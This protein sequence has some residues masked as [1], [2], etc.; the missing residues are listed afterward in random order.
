MVHT[1][2]IAVVVSYNGS[3]D[4]L[5]TV[6]ALQNRVG[7]IHI[8]DN[9]SSH[10]T[11]DILNKLEQESDISIT[12]LNKNHGIGYALNIG[13][14]KGGELGFN[15]ILTMDQDSRVSD[16]MVEEFCKVI[17]LNCKLSCLTPTISIFENESS[18]N[19]TMN[20][21]NIVK[22]AITSG[23]LIRL[24]VFETVGLYNEELFIDCVDFDF[25]LRLRDAG[26]TINLV[27]QAKLFHQLGDV[28]DVP[29]I[30]SWFYTSHS[31]L[32]RYY[33]YRNWGFMIERYSFKFPLFVLK[34]SI[35]HILLLLVIPFYDK[36]P[37]ES[38]KFIY[39]GLRDYFKNQYG[40]LKI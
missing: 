33:M 31:V 23:N 3:N 29:K 12:Y 15:W 6:S 34:S 25:S 36:K 9:A 24:D 26:F 35:I 20:K 22:Y 30:F 10:M 19:T 27:P 14:R 4:I 7:H 5:Q 8:V 18:F 2:I 13:V 16:T 1:E 38:F 40:P 37:K 32:R 21:E 28:H 39:Y 17:N 11:L